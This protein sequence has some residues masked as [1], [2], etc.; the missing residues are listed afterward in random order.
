ME[1]GYEVRLRLG[2]MNSVKV[3]L[4]NRRMTVEVARKTGKSAELWCICN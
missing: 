2:W 1:G 3:A 4:G